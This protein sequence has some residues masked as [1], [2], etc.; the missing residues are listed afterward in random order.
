MI[1]N[2]YTK[3]RTLYH[4]LKFYWSVNWFATLYFNFKKF[5]FETAKKIPVFFY[6]KVKFTSI[7]GKI[8]IDAPLRK[9]MIGFGQPYELN[10]LHK[11]TAEV[12]ITGT[13]VFKG[14][15]QFG[16]D[17]FVI[18]RKDAYCELGHLSSLGSGGKLICAEKIV[19]GDYARLGSEC[20][21]IDTNFHQM[22]DTKTGEVYKMT[23]PIQIGSYN[24]V[25]NRVTFMKGAK[26]PD[27]CTIASN[28]VC[29]KDY[30]SLGQNTLIGGVPSKLIRENISRDWEAEKELLNKWVII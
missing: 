27:Y 14:H 18:V 6:G 11:G 29:S 3:G 26:T 1:R 9:G 7:T 21:V 24:F 22:F 19:L 10:T 28:S 30:T 20:Q 4:Q 5:P 12:N 16:K 8:Q 2:S 17:C 23:S 13:L 15:V 25:S